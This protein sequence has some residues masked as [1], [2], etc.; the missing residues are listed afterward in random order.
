MLE[1]RSFRVKGVL[2]NVLV[3]VQNPELMS[4]AGTFPDLCPYWS[5]QDPH[6][7]RWPSR[8]CVSRSSSPSLRCPTSSVNQQMSSELRPRFSFFLPPSSGPRF[9]TASISYPRL[10]FLFLPPS[11]P[12]LPSHRWVRAAGRKSSSVFTFCRDAC[13]PASLRARVQNVPAGIVH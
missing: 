7:T 10:V 11:S 8:S 3:S 9:P 1:K 5:P 2:M 12:S 6:R 4:P 13:T